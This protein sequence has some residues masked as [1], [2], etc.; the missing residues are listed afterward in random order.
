MKPGNYHLPFHSA[1]VGQTL[2][3]EEGCRGQR[4]LG[5]VCSSWLLPALI[6][7]PCVGC[8]RGQIGSVQ[9]HV[10]AA[11]LDAAAGLALP[12]VGALCILQIITIFFV[13][14]VWRPAPAGARGGRG[15]CLRWGAMVVLVRASRRCRLRGCERGSD[16]HPT[17]CITPSRT[18]HISQR[19]GVCVELTA[20]NC[21]FTNYHAKA[22]IA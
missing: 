7:T 16:R 3:K 12:S 17:S 20:P 18:R 21:F 1:G 15:G 6:L 5:N 14:Q 8:E 10:C 11:L 22:L 4:G 19:E 9:C 2:W 13:C